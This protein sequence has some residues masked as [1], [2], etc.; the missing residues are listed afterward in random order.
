MTIVAVVTRRRFLVGRVMVGAV[1]EMIADVMI[2]VV[3]D[4]GKLALRRQRRGLLR[5]RSNS[6]RR[7]ASVAAMATM[8]ATARADVAG[9]TVT[10]ATRADPN[11]Q[12]KG[13]RSLRDRAPCCL[14][15][16]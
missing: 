14:G 7:V 6:R 10:T 15:T 2:V 12:E 8:M 1:V 9:M 11:G 4:R 16:V 13:A 3:V 5:R